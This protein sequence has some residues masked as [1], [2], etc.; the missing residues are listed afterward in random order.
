MNLIVRDEGGQMLGARKKKEPPDVNVYDI[1]FQT[2]APIVYKTAFFILKQEQDAEEIVQETFLIAFKKLHT[3]RDQ[4]KFKQ[5]VCTIACNLSKKRYRKKKKEVLFETTD[6]IVALSRKLKD[7][8]YEPGQL[9]QN[10]EAK[11]LIMHEL[12]R[13]DP[14]F[15]EVIVLY[16]YHQFTYEEIAEMLEINIGTVKSRLSRGKRKLMKHI[17]EEEW[18]EVGETI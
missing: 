10:K 18:N 4:K 12:D 14:I 3:L 5:W 2:Y 7:E 8:T 11:R 9:L 1:L 6:K 13:L 16:Y 17:G 15:R